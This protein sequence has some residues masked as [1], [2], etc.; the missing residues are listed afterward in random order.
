VVTKMNNPENEVVNDYFTERNKEE[1]QK[2]EYLKKMWREVNDITENEQ[3]QEEA[4]EG[5]KDYLSREGKD[6]LKRAKQ[7][8]KTEIEIEEALAKAEEL[9]GRTTLEGLKIRRNVQRDTEIDRNIN[10]VGKY[11]KKVTSLFV[12]TI[13]KGT[14]DYY[15][16]KDLRNVHKTT[17]DIRDA[18]LPS[19]SLHDA[20]VPVQQ[21]MD[22]SSLHKATAASKSMQ[23]LN[24]LKG[25]PLKEA[26]KPQARYAP[27]LGRLQSASAPN[28]SKLGSMIGQMP[29]GR[30]PLARASVPSNKL[31]RTIQFNPT[32]V[33]SSTPIA[34]ASRK[35][36]STP[37]QKFKEVSVKPMSI[38]SNGI[39]N[40]LKEVSQAS[41]KVKP[42]FDSKLSQVSQ[43]PM[44]LSN[45]I[46][47]RLSQAARTPMRVRNTT[48]GL[49]K[50]PNTSFY[51]KV[52]GKAKK[53]VR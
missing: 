29:G 46:G 42:D 37:S 47:N 11:T 5:A 23:N 52:L 2:D 9:K 31:A 33:S 25:S 3:L 41:L 48:L 1:D 8:Q 15:L 44:R 49:A 24:Q 4:E 34:E 35:T 21:S 28:T 27:Q 14:K 38:N 36:R 43:T 53:Q 50:K 13:A 26:A 17:K 45:P 6:A 10:R 39:G 16:P 7:R 19:E 18:A 20:V 40:K 12:P 22:L 51:R 30:T 32:F